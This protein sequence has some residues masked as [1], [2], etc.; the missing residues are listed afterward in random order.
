MGYYCF[1]G[2]WGHMNCEKLLKTL[3]IDKIGGKSEHYKGSLYKT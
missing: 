2:P 3:K 1:G